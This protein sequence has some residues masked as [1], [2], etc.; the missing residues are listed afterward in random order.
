MCAQ[1]SLRSAWASVQRLIRVFTVRMETPWVLSDPLSAQW[2][3]WSDWVDAQADPSIQWV[4]RFFVCFVMR[5]LRN[6]M[7]WWNCCR[8]IMTGLRT[9]ISYICNRCDGLVTTVWNVIY[10]YYNILSI[11][12]VKLSSFGTDWH[13]QTVQTQVKTDPEGAVW[14]EST[15]FAIPSTS[16]FWTHC[17]MLNLPCSSLWG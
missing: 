1:R 13:E 14:W 15:L 6:E 3:L 10:I 9:I 8:Q 5:W 7:K 11:F 16:F 4:Q 12:T 17:R 2:R